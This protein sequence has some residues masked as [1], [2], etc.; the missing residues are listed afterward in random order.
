MG[1]C[2]WT[3]K[4]CALRPHKAAVA[5]DK[6]L[7]HV[8]YFLL[9]MSHLINKCSF[10]TILVEGFERGSSRI[11]VYDKMQIMGSF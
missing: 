2:I 7:K 6:L 3:L 11:K 4:W 5:S 8:I 10:I 1:V 9:N